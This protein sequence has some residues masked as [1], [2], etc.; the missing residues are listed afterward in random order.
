MY[1]QF[2]ETSLASHAEKTEA[3]LKS[4]DEDLGDADEVEVATDKFRADVAALKEREEAAADRARSTREKLEDI[5]KAWA[6]FEQLLSLLQREVLAR[7]TRLDIVRARKD[8]LNGDVVRRDLQQI[9]VRGS[10]PA[11]R[12]SL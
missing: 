2:L 3:I 5:G 7:R 9:E 12:V 8:V 6:E 10:T 4:L 11:Y 1:F